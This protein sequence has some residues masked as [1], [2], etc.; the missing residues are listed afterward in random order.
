VHEGEIIA[1][2]YRV[3]RVLGEGGMGVVVAVTH[4][5]LHQRFAMKFLLPE[6]ASMPALVMRFTREAQAAV[7][8]QSEH[9]ARVTDV[10]VLPS[11]APYMLMEYLEG[12]DL[13]QVLTE[14]GALPPLDTA[15]YALQALEA[16][17]E[18]H[19]LG[20]VHRDLKPGNLFLAQ[21]PSGRSIIKV[22]DFGIS[23]VEA[24]PTS[25][26]LTGHN[27][28]MGS[29]GY[30]SPE[31]MVEPN[32]VDRTT[33]I[34]AMGVVLYEMLSGVRPF[35]APTMPELVAIVLAKPQ[36][37]L[38]Q[39]RPDL[40]PGL[41]EVID[42]CLMKDKT[43]R[44][45]DVGQ[46]AR[47]LAPFAPGHAAQSVE[48]ILGVLGTGGHA[49][50]LQAIP[51]AP[52]SAARGPGTFSPTSSSGTPARSSAPIVIGIGVI[53]VALLAGGGAAVWKLR[54][55]GRLASTAVSSGSVASVPSAP[56][57]AVEKLS[58][59]PTP[60]P[61]ELDAGATLTLSSA[62]ALPSASSAPSA[63]HAGRPRAAAPPAASSA[64][65]AS[66][67]PQ[68]HTVSYFDDQGEKHFKQECQ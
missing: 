6:V 39:I 22:L 51:L 61:A 57:S 63:P 66:S 30:M 54:S 13:G 21:R 5:G 55:S 53:A 24:S 65:P 59:A 1:E 52:L 19:S 43:A 60:P 20:I 29:P 11:G 16:L 45:Q 14:R 47:A 62:S 34:W 32:S 40:P 68:C 15:G 17:A 35:D 4:L 10:G 36:V 56:G 23:K 7:R 48:R 28:L 27:A 42:R 41:S 31:Q 8:I 64:A 46:L 3:D 37:P 26:A 49:T 2:K 38:R 50:S 58:A 33:D 12:Q 18:A 9:V 67:T 44:Y 25:P